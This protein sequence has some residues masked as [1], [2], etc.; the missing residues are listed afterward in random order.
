MPDSKRGDGPVGFPIFRNSYHGFWS[1]G[2][3][4]VE[5]YILTSFSR[6]NRNLLFYYNTTQGSE[7]FVSFLKDGRA[8]VFNNK[9]YGFVFG[10]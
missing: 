8:K 1:N 4:V 6:S 2:P 9:R 5:K 7:S 10:S 3:E